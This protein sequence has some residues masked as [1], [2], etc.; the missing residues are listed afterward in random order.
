MMA[1]LARHRAGAGGVR[2]SI[3]PALG[4]TLLALS[5]AAGPVGATVILR[6]HYSD[7]YAFSFDDCGFWIDVAGNV[8]GT[9]QIRVGKGD[10]TTAFFLHDNYAFLETWTRRDT[11]DTFTLGG[12]GLFQETTATPVEGTIFAF[13]SINAGQPFIVWDSD[14]NL[15]MRDRGVVRQVIQ[16]D[17][18]GDDVP[19]GEFVADV[20]FS[21]SGPHPGLDVDLCALLD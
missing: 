17:T 11:G 21:V 1:H 14:G 13:T 16:F 15:V 10:L 8:E 7:D 4:A 5:L 6:D 12:N 19:G 18:L 2:R 20:S 9:A 3:I